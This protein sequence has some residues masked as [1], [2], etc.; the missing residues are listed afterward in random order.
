MTET[1]VEL[2]LR[3]ELGNCRENTGLLKRTL[4]FDLKITMN[5]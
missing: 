2:L 1:K 3:K 5:R 4:P